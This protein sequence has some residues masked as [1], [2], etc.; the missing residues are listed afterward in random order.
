MAKIKKK[1]VLGAAQTY[2]TRT[3]A[4]KKLQ[5]SLADFRRLCILKGVYPREPSNKKKAS[6]NNNANN[7]FY[8][9][10]DIRF[11]LHEP[12]VQKI[13]DRKAFLRKLRKAI[14]KHQKSVV[15]SLEKCEPKY[16][17]DHVVKER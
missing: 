13:R 14:G 8:F 1:G 10:K 9:A 15:E 4:I 7:T 12:I 2:M 3:R 16:T 17:L 6:G 5:L 11:L